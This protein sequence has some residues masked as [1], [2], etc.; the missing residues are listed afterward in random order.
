MLSFFKKKK[1]PATR[2]LTQPAELRVGDI[3]VL[4][5]R[6]SLA[7]EL[8]GQQ[9]E[10]TDVGTYQYSSSVEK[11]CTLRSAENKTYYMSTDDNDGDPLLCFALKI[12]R[13]AVLEIFVEDSFAQLWDTDYASLKVQVK[14]ERYA[15]WLTDEYY[16]NVK[17]AE[18]YFYDRDCSDQPPSAHLDDDAEELRYHECEG[19][20]DTRFGVTVEVWGDGDTDVFLHLSCPVDVIDEMWPHGNA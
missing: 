16:Q 10:V 6:R 7:P 13:A 12:P 19:V 8:Q 15:S 11:T 5:E 2:T 4:K 17:E 9:L 18:A 20:P 14:P 3:V 1:Q